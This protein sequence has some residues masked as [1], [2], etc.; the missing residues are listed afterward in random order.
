MTKY[1]YPTEKDKQTLFTYFPCGCENKETVQL[2]SNTKLN[3][4]K[5]K[6]GQYFLEH[7]IHVQSHGIGVSYTISDILFCYL[8]IFAIVQLIFSYFYLK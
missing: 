5:R 8:L 6:K 4:Q 7:D 2:G 1:K 3:D